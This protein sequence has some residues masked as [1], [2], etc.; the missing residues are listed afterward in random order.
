MKLSKKRFD[1]LVRCW[2]RKLHMYDPPEAQKT[3]DVDI[4]TSDLKIDC[5]VRCVYTTMCGSRVVHFVVCVLRMSC[6]SR[7][8]TQIPW[9]S[10]AAP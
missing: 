8:R 3:Q 7:S 5:D 2:R 1:G 10:I 6:F 9:V 4:D